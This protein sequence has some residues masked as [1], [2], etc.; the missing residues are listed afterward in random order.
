MREFNYVAEKKVVKIDGRTYEV[1][2]RSIAIAKAC[3]AIQT[4]SESANIF[5][6]AQAEYDTVVA[7]LGEDSCKEILGDF[8]TCDIAKLAQLSNF[9]LEDF[10]NES[11]D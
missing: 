11:A 8:E 3:Q 7:I 9:L 2:P 6:L 4:S 1:M 10:N 5:E